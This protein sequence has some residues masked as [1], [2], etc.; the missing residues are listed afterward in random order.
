MKS[1][2]VTIDDCCEVYS[3][4]LICIQFRN[5]VSLAQSLFFCEL[6]IGSLQIT[7]QFI[8][9]VLSCHIKMTLT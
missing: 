4:P 8:V 2:K 5:L 1:G 9:F 3:Y 7:S 6:G